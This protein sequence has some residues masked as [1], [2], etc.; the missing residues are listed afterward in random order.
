MTNILF[1]IELNFVFTLI[2]LTGPNG[3]AFAGKGRGL[4]EYCGYPH[5]LKTCGKSI[6]PNCDAVI[7]ITMLLIT[8]KLIANFFS[9]ENRYQAQEPVTS[10]HCP[11]SYGIFPHKTSCSKYYQCWNNTASEQVSYIL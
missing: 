2:R 3:L 7:S 11:F 10:E 8:F 9:D 4:Y 5:V 6:S 1:F